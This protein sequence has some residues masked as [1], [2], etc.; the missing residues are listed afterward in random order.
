MSNYRYKYVEMYMRN[1]NTITLTIYNRPAIAKKLNLT[2]KT[3]PKSHIFDPTDEVKYS[4]NVFKLDAICG[5]LNL[6]VN[7]VR[8]IL[9]CA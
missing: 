4:S 9:A 6:N 8:E 3:Y 2:L 7:K 1:S 5:L